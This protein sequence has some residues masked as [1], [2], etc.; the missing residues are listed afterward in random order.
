MHLKPRPFYRD[1]HTLFRKTPDVDITVLQR[2]FDHVPA[3]R[4]FAEGQRFRTT[5]R[6]EITCDG[7]RL[8]PRMPL[9]QP[10]SV[11]KL[12]KY[13]GI[14]RDYDDAPDML[15]QSEAFQTMI[16]DWL[17]MTGTKAKT[18]SVHQIRTT[19]T[20]CPVP[21]G[22]HHD[23]TDW[24]GLYVVKRH[25]IRDDSAVTTYWDADGQILLQDVLQEGE[26][27]TFYDERYT[28]DTT[29]LVPLDGAA[30]R[31]VFVLTLPEHGD[32]IRGVGRS[33]KAAA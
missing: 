17:E 13:G 11:N 24:T 21:E 33:S 9:Y 19:G 5:S 25:L 16:N 14:E 31:D 20:G 26:L 4:Y 7:F 30:Y 10:P 23:G 22:R 6:V 18:F 2:S 28:H 32:N 15:I 3:D 12:T 29:A 8:L 27:I 1:G